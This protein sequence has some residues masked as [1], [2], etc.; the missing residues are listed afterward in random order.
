[1]L[2]RFEGKARRERTRATQ[3][4]IVAFD[5]GGA[6]GLQAAHTRL[7]RQRLG[8]R[9]MSALVDLV[10][11]METLLAVAKDI[12]EWV[13]RHGVCEAAR[14][15]LD[16]PPIRWQASLPNLSTRLLQEEAVIFYGRH[17]SMLTPILLA[18]AIGRSDLK[19]VAASY[20]AKLGPH[21]AACSFP[22]YAAAPV[23]MR[24]AG[25]K[26]LSSR[27]AG[28]IAWKSEGGLAREDARERNRL[29]LAAAAAHVRNGGGLLIAPDSRDRREP[30]RPG[31][32]T[33]VA[34]LARDPGPRT[35]YLVPWKIQRASISAVF[36]ILSR[37]PLVRAYGRRRFR[38]PI[39]VSFGEPNTLQSIVGKTGLRP[40]DITAQL[41]A[42]YRRL[43]F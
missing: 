8:Y 14:L 35:T 22:V 12:D 32:G 9:V 37:N 3:E 30:W 6:A 5:A 26:G 27:I 18:A 15:A 29:A 34:A 19:M 36:Q 28:W 40:A 1:M 21:T 39:R 2:V 41:E 38:R 20:I 24:K 7:R 33:L 23:Q 17:G 4:L 31:I 11:P 25:R 43:R 13:G 16:G 42:D 10:V